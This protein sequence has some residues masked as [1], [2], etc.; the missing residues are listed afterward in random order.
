[1]FHFQQCHSVMARC[2]IS[3]TVG[4]IFNHSRV[5]RP[6]SKHACALRVMKTISRCFWTGQQLLLWD[7][8][9]W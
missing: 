7:M 2:V 5:E 1:M 4:V 3:N 8:D 6:S 9:R